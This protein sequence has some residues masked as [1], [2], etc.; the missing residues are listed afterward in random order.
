[1][2][3][4]IETIAYLTGEWVP[5]S[6]I[7]VHVHDR[8]FYIGDSVFDLARTFNGKSFKMKEHVDRL[9]RSLKHVR[10]DPGLSPE[11]MVEVSEE[12][13]RRNEKFRKDAG[14]WHVWQAVTRG[15]AGWRELPTKA[16]VIVQCA[17]ISFK[18]YA[19]QFKTG[20]HAVIA[21]TRSYSPETVDPKVKH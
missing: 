18:I 10:I 6:E 19:H 17:P 15:V 21:K 7:K 13:V 8:G 9:Y 14:D 2:A 5:L 1:M 16:T 11:E 20:A 4:G 12:C 3:K